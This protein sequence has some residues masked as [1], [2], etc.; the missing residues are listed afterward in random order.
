MEQ[1]E[2]GSINIYICP[3]CMEEYYE[4]EEMMACW[5]SDVGGEVK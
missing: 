3:A 4:F 1:N 2:D 5:K